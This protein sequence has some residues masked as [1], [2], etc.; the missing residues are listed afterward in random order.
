MDLFIELKNEFAAFRK[1]IYSKVDS[2]STLICSTDDTIQKEEPRLSLQQE[3]IET[4]LKSETSTYAS[5]AQTS[6]AIPE[7][8]LFLQKNVTLRFPFWYSMET[9]RL[10]KKK[11]TVRKLALKGV[12]PDS[13]GEFKS[14]R[15]SVKYNIQKDYNTYL[16]HTESNLISDPKKFWSYFKN[17]NINSL[18]SLFYNNVCYENDGNI[19]NAFA[20]YFSS[21]FKPSTVFDG[22]DECKSNC[23]GDL[24]KIESVTYDNVVLDIR[25]LKSSLT[26]GVD[27]IPSYI[28]KG[29]IEFLIYPFLFCLTCR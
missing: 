9:R 19:A 25:V 22:N 16:R 23:I 7:A 20:D 26:V 8:E 15:S 11:V 6:S 18:D 27:N 21:V 10:I 28:I 4:E 14:F 17:K 13:F 3:I 24:V 12:N 1:H 5:V 29:C 2:F